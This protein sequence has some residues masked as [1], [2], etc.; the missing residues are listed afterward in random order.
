[1]RPFKTKKEARE[2]RDANVTGSCGVEL[3]S[4]RRGQ[5]NR[6]LIWIVGSSREEVESEADKHGYPR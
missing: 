1:M 2:W 6:Q 5:K 3:R 4:R